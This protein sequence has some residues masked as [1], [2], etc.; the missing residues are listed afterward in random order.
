MNIY[1]SG[2]LAYDN[3]MEF[4]DKFQNHII[5]ENLNNINVSFMVGNSTSRLGGTA[6]NISYALKLLK[7]NPIILATLGKDDIRYIEWL[8]SNGIS[9]ANIRMIENTPTA[10]ATIVTDTSQNQITIFDPGAMNFPSQYN[11]E[12][13]KESI[14]LWVGPGNLDDMNEYPKL[15]RKCDIPYMFDPG[16]SLPAWEEKDLLSAIEGSKLLIANSYEMQMIE[17]KTKRTINQLL[18]LTNSVIVTRGENGCTL[19]T[20]NSSINL[21]SA[22]IQNVIDPTGAGD[23]FRGGLLKGIGDG[24]TIEDSCKIGA[25]A[26][27]YCVQSH[28]T[29]EYS[30]TL[31]EFYTRLE[32]YKGNL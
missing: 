23:A 6:G 22:P 31:E 12:L 11:I 21:P 25:V 10:T 15:A 3:I 1:I 32:I 7:G 14:I 24:E 29:Q 20:D 8:H 5:A 26:A 18:L 28:G 30:F 17:E 2:S 13:I 9:T 4:P 27:A 19:F 16:Q